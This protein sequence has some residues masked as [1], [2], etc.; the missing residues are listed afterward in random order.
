MNVY[1]HPFILCKNSLFHTDGITPFV[2][3]VLGDKQRMSRFCFSFPSSSAA[4]EASDGAVTKAH[5]W[6]DPEKRKTALVQFVRK[7]LFD[8]QICKTCS[9]DHEYVIHRFEIR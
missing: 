7:H 6:R 8:L 3:K 1:T 9:K 5:S 2:I 4:S